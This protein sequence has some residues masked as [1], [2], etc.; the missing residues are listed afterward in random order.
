MT[1]DSRYFNVNKNIYASKIFTV[2]AI[3]ND[4]YS[5]MHGLQ[6][7]DCKTSKAKQINTI[8]TMQPCVY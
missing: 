8:S 1:F 6:Y 4:T 2:I 5:H 7:C 3:L